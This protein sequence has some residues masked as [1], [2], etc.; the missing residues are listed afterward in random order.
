MGSKKEDLGKQDSVYSKGKGE[1]PERRLV[2]AG[3]L[4]PN[5]SEAYY[6]YRCCSVA[7]LYMGH[8]L[9]LGRSMNNRAEAKEMRECHLISRQF[10][11]RFVMV[12][13][14]TCILFKRK[15]KEMREKIVRALDYVAI[16]FIYLN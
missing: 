1:Y 12:A 15:R 2:D 11:T 7:Y 5:R 4:M 6:M 10:Y 16:C 13:G 8:G 3:A 9:N 14:R